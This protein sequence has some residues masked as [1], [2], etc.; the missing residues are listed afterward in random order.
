M[1]QDISREPLPPSSLLL[2]HACGKR[3]LSLVTQAKVLRKSCKDTE[4]PAVRMTTPLISPND[5]RGLFLS[6]HPAPRSEEQLA[7]PLPLFPSTFCVPHSLLASSKPAY[8]PSWML[9]IRNSED[10]PAHWQQAA[11][12]LRQSPTH[13][14]LSDASHLLRKRRLGCAPCCELFGCISVLWVGPDQNFCKFVTVH[15]TQRGCHKNML[16]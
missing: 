1:T 6:N 9:P 4:E 11:R 5:A 3:R 2:P 12:R 10:E 13:S 16:Q 8:E 7:D 15:R 14:S